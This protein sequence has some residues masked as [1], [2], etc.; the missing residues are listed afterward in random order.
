M[1]MGKK[2]VGYYIEESLD[3]SLN[4]LA[5]RYEGS[6][7]DLAAAA[8]WMFLNAASEAKAAA[9]REVLGRSADDLFGLTPPAASSAPATTAASGVQSTDQEVSVDLDEVRPETPKV[10]ERK[11]ARHKKA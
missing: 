6:K 4:R 5:E 8:I 3:I 1:L 10:K 7:G 2:K 9:L 11:P